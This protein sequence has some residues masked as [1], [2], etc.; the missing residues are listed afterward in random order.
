MTVKQ[1]YREWLKALRSGKYKQGKKRLITVKPDGTCLHCCLG[2][3]CEV[4]GLERGE[5]Y[6]EGGYMYDG[7]HVSA[8]LPAAIA[9][10]VGL[11]R[12]LNSGKALTDS[13]IHDND[14]R[15]RGFKDIANRIETRILPKLDEETLNSEVPL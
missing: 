15:R 14:T 7:N 3:A 1:F 6:S 13:L 8:S 2:V 12:Q 11:F 5:K 10:A 4:L 9:G